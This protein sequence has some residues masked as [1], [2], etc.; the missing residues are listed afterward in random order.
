MLEYKLLKF[1]PDYSAAEAYL[2]FGR[3][4]SYKISEN[5]SKAEYDYQGFEYDSHAIENVCNHAAAMAK[6]I[7]HN[8]MDESARAAIIRDYRNAIK[9]LKVGKYGRRETID[10]FTE[11]MLEEEWQTVIEAVTDAYEDNKTKDQENLVEN[12]F[13]PDY[14][15]ILAKRGDYALFCENDYE[16]AIRI[17][18]AATYEWR[19]KYV[20]RDDN[21]SLQ[22]GAK[23][24]IHKYIELFSSVRD[25]TSLD[26]DE[27]FL[28]DNEKTLI[29]KYRRIQRK[30]NQHES[31]IVEVEDLITF[32]ESCIRNTPVPNG[33]YSSV[34][35]IF[36]DHYLNTLRTICLILPKLYQF[37]YFDEVNQL[38]EESKVI[39]EFLVEKALDKLSYLEGSDLEWVADILCYYDEKKRW[40]ILSLLAN[41]L[42]DIK[43]IKRKLLIK[44]RIPQLAY[45]TTWD[46]FS[47]MLPKDEEDGHPKDEEDENYNVGKLSVMHLSYMNDPMEGKVIN[48]FLFGIENQNGRKIESQPYVFIKCFTQSIDYLPMWKMY[49]DDAKG[50][51]VV[52]NWNKTKEKNEGRDIALYKVCYLTKKNGKYVFQ[53]ND[54]GN[55][56]ALNGFGAILDTVIQVFNDMNTVKPENVPAA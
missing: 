31:I 17:Y 25:G 13:I 48:E 10:K 18:L 53:K 37:A 2:S 51:C 27:S 54:N 28:S 39:Q 33:Y 3:I 43:E 50:C 34:H 5:E 42:D 56:K 44:E 11:Y 4:P 41:L 6:R 16:K 47:Y 9:C 49:G 14:G 19:S 8:R 1:E 36:E 32:I 23:H 7:E 15:K 55:D 45:Y 24:K 29:A 30:Y 35:P 20:G 46:T 26:E 52:I 21:H 40:K 38:S 22:V 12:R